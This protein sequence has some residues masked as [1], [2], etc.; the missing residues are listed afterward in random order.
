M[1]CS[2]LLV[3]TRLCAPLTQA[4]CRDASTGLEPWVGLIVGPYDQALES[5]ASQHQVRWPHVL[6]CMKHLHLSMPASQP[7][8]RM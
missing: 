5:P 8:V 3:Q 6:S 2:C 1:S 7:A 4:L